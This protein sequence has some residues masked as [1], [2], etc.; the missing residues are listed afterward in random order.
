M[1]GTIC[2]VVIGLSASLAKAQTVTIQNLPQFEWVASINNDG[3]IAGI[4][5]GRAVIAKP[6]E[7]ATVIDG[8]LGSTSFPRVV[9][10]RGQVAGEYSVPATGARQAFFYDPDLGTVDLFVADT[11]VFSSTIN[12]LGQMFW[13]TSTRSDQRMHVRDEAGGITSIAIPGGYVFDAND[14]GQALSTVFGTVAGVTTFSEGTLSHLEIDAPSYFYTELHDINNVGQAVGRLGI[15]DRAA[16]WDGDNGLRELIGPGEADGFDHI[17]SAINDHGLV[18]LTLIP[19]SRWW[20]SEFAYYSL[21]GG[22]I[23]LE[24]PVIREPASCIPGTLQMSTSAVVGFSQT[25]RYDTL[26]NRGQ[27]LVRIR[28]QCQ[29]GSDFP[30]IEIPAI[31]TVEK[32]MQ[33]LPLPRGL[34]LEDLF[35]EVADEFGRIVN[36]YRWV[37]FSNGALNDRGKM[38]GNFRTRSWDGTF[39][40]TA[41]LYDLNPTPIADVK[42][43]GSDYFLLVSA[44]ESVHVTLS[45]APGGRLGEPGEYWGTLLSSTGNYPL[46]GFQAELFELGETSLFD[47]PLPPGWYVFLFNVEDTPDE[48]YQLGWFD[49][50][51]VLVTP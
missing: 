11:L 21:D 27:A 51:I 6:G 43:N 48:V 23:R 41:H 2:A 44:T 39:E 10:D 25:L 12:D 5:G 37:D 19:E 18:A 49:F 20:D 29:V 15:P 50:V 14:R 36:I 22:L 4:A 28:L 24:Q 9:N 32:G 8:G 40:S 38:I 13:V 35:R 33:I 26:N 16:F 45:F 30:I 47:G 42:A 3:L 17:A 7:A 31:A 34:Q 1:R 46:F